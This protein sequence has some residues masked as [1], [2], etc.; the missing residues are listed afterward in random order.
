MHTLFI[1]GAGA[2][3]DYGLPVGNALANEIRLRAMA[4]ASG[5]NLTDLGK[6]GEHLMNRYPNIVDRTPK[7]AALKK[8]AERIYPAASI[9]RFIEQN[10][11]DQSVTEMGKVLIA[12]CIADAE[13]SGSLSLDAGEKVELFASPVSASWCD[14]FLKFLVRGEHWT[15]VDEM[16]GRNYSVVCFNYDRCLER[17]LIS[18]LQQAFGLRYSAAWDLVYNKLKILHPYGQLGRLPSKAPEGDDGI[19]YGCR[20]TD[21]WVMAKNIRTFTEQSTDRSGD[22]EVYKAIDRADRIVFLGFS[23]EQLNMEMMRIYPSKR[24]RVFASAFGIEPSQESE[25]SSRIRNMLGVE[26]DDAQH[27]SVKFAFGKSCKQTLD[28]YYYELTSY[29]H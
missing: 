22:A 15:S 20:L 24:R 27:T 5:N 21:P 16:L 7:M 18:G 29:L 23:F 19:A 8:I 4:L 13:A 25:L 28:D 3:Y 26:P 12:S 17:Y 10:N 14:A 11:H 2:S 1:V 9:D 6:V